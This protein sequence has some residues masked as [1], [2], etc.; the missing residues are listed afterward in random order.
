M[1]PEQFIREFG[2]K[3]AREVV[4]GAP[5]LSECFN[6]ENGGYYSCP[7]PSSSYLAVWSVTNDHIQRGLQPRV[8]VLLDL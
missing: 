4:E 6:P 3:K 2:E 7:N 8:P 5:K 1:K